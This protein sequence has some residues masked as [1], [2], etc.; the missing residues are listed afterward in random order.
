MVVSRMKFTTKSAPLKRFGI[1][2]ITALLLAPTIL[3]IEPYFNTVDA[4][5]LAPPQSRSG[6]TSR[7]RGLD[8]DM[9]LTRPG[10]HQ[11]MTIY[12]R[13]ARGLVEERLY[14]SIAIGDV[15]GDNYDD[16]ILGSRED[17]VTGR[18]NCG[19][20]Y[21]IFGS[22]NLPASLDLATPSSAF[23]PIYGNNSNDGIGTAVTVCDFNGDGIGDIIIGASEDSK[24]FIIYG[25]SYLKT[26]TNWDLTTTKANVT[27]WGAFGDKFGYSLAAADLNSDNFDDILIGAPHADGPGDARPECGEIVLIQG[28]NKNVPDIKLDSTELPT[29]NLTII[30]GID[31]T[32]ESGKAIATGDDFNGDGIIDIAIG[33]PNGDGPPISPTIDGGEAYVL[34]WS[35]N[36]TSSWDLANI[37]TPANFTLFA[38]QNGDHLGSSVAF[39]N[40]NN[41]SYSDLIVGA[42]DA[43]ETYVI[44]G[45]PFHEPAPF[46]WQL[47]LTIADVCVAFPS[48][49][50]KS[51]THVDAFDWN[52][53]GIDDLAITAPN[54]DGPGNNYANAGEMVIINGL[55][56]LQEQIN[57]DTISPDF[58]FF[59][60]DAGDLLG[61]RIVHGDVD[62]DNI[63]DLAMIANDADGLN[64]TRENSGEIYV[65]RGGLAFSPK[66]NFLKLLNGNGPL[67]DSCYA[68]L[69]TYEFEVNFT[70]IR[71]ITDLVNVTLI[72]DP[73]GLALEYTWERSSDTFSVKNDP[74]HYTKLL[75]GSDNSTSGGSKWRL[76]FNIEFNWTCPF[77]DQ[78]P[79][80][81]QYWD[82][83][84]CFTRNYLN[85]FNIETRLNFDGE[86]IVK[87]EKQNI[88]SSGEWI[89]G[90]GSI[91]WSNLTVIYENSTNIYPRAEHYKVKLWNATYN[92]T[93]S[94][95][96]GS[97][98]DI[99]IPVG[100]K[101][102]NY[103]YIINITKI[104]RANDISNISFQLN[105]DGENIQ[106]TD[107]IPSMDEWQN[108]PTVTCGIS[109]TDIGGNKV[110]AN[111][112]QFRIS[113]DNGTTW[114][115][116]TS[117]GLITDDYEITIS[118]DIYFPDG[119]DNLI[120]WRG[121]DTLGN[122]YGYSPQYSIK[123]DTTN[124]TFSNYTPDTDVNFN[125]RIIRFGIDISDNTSGV[126]ASTIQYTYSLD[127]G[128]SWSNWLNPG[129]EGTNLSVHAS[130]IINFNTG[131]GNLVKWRAVDVAG[132]GPTLSLTQRFRIFIADSDL[133]T[134]LKLP[135]NNSQVG[136]ATPTLKWISNDN[137]SNIKFDIYLDTDQ[138]KLIDL[139]PNSEFLEKVGGIID[140]FYIVKTKL[141]DGETYY[142]TVVPW[143]VTGSA[144]ECDDGIWNFKI[145]LDIP[146]IEI[147]MI[148]L[149]YPIND[150]EVISLKPTFIWELDYSNPVG[151]LFDINLGTSPN[152]LNMTIANLGVN[153]YTWSL[154]LKNNASYYWNV[155]VHGGDILGK[156]TSET[157]KFTTNAPPAMD[158]YNYKMEVNESSFK[159]KQ[160]ESKS[161]S[162]TITNLKANK[163]TVMLSVDLEDPLLDTMFGLVPENIT[164]DFF[165]TKYALLL[166]NIPS[167]FKSGIYQF[168]V[169]GKM[170]TNIEVI[171]KSLEFEIRI[172]RASL[173]KDGDETDKNTYL[174]YLGS[175]I[176]III[177]LLTLFFINFMRKKKKQR[178][179]SLEGDGGERGDEEALSKPGP[180]PGPGTPSTP[181]VPMQT[182]VPVPAPAPEQAPPEPQVEPAPKMYV[183]IPAEEVS[184]PKQLEPAKPAAQPIGRPA[185][186]VRTIATATPAQRALPPVKKPDS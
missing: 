41:D 170:E 169:T 161:I 159:L 151:V 71:K 48:S 70:T 2:L 81:I 171:E 8:F 42:V 142:W 155:C 86:L 96:P 9:N 121:N 75:S 130:A 172:I 74:N 55:E 141:I 102:I 108:Q 183:A 154:F 59:G 136:N 69:K 179:Q 76:L 127:D 123:V 149:K 34:Y 119:N 122:G 19:I 148:N 23:L 117:A 126:N 61:Y 95:P 91:T 45:S 112:M 118:K 129:L 125:T 14:D 52:W 25:G 17:N 115:N 27:I 21:V 101:S 11:D 90:A 47:A 160:G 35:L 72:L 54:G 164:L 49:N 144:G 106:F 3:M 185:Q 133:K 99:T 28:F 89:R 26:L 138:N 93:D 103:T 40:I 128:Q 1:L 10:L 30:Y 46:E 63:M 12:G 163:G 31:S 165:E 65:L 67:N 80:Q 94:N 104:P 88:L 139:D 153:E 97:K 84:Q 73:N 167:E 13:K 44:Y 83:N 29:V 177:I 131:L 137:S 51:G 156:Y 6:S 56:G 166:I 147:P 120:Q 68:K 7:A 77:G 5:D 85:V 114:S 57:L 15:N 111:S 175:V 78:L 58:Y 33:V 16:I 134:N 98:I 182:Q 39:G 100:Q 107:P 64:N 110:T 92:W 150:Q 36:I 38:E 116:W 143:N 186:T 162:I 24:V 174:I 180:G 4:D 43:G 32:D 60:A 79:I 105:I 140:N 184:Q 62:G 176:I 145:N 157:E 113:N 18:E 109:V 181:P 152:S 20:V 173:E 82:N 53:D 66:I 87:D 22:P 158:F 168:N 146:E 132:N 178:E 50:D 124:I 37:A 135:R